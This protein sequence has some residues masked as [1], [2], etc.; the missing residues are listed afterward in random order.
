MAEELEILKGNRAE[1]YKSL[2]PQIKALISDEKNEVANLANI[3]AALRQTFGFFWV[4]FYSVDSISELVLGPFQGDI[5]CTRITKGKGVC[6]T[7]WQN[8]KTIIVDNV[9]DFKGHIAC[10]S[11]SK[12]EIVVPILKQNK[13]RLILD[14]D[15]DKLNDFSIIDQQYLE[16]LADIISETLCD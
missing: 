3:A 14:V 15:S 7:A 8:S 4:G 11:L 16:E 5:A 10:S 2:L 6:G 12:S 9:D 13:V 1:M